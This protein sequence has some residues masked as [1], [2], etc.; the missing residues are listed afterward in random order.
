MNEMCEAL[1][2]KMAVA[3]L[4][5][6]GRRMMNPL[7]LAYVG[8]AVHEMF[9]RTY[10]VSR[11]SGSVN[12]LN[13]KVVSVIKATAQAKVLCAVMDQLTEEEI[14]V[15]KRGRNAK[16]LTV[17]KNTSVSEYRQA[18]GFEALLGHLFLSGNNERLIELV[19]LSVSLIEEESHA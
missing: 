16:S 2:E 14:T 9:V 15:V 6:A 13:Q 8:D 5:E 1:L 11:Y 7:S 3:P 19:A 17:P 4:D 10:V 12:K 18:T